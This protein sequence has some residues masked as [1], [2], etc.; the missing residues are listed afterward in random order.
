[1]RYSS[2]PGSEQPQ[3]R[4]SRTVRRPLDVMRVFVCTVLD[5]GTVEVN[6]IDAD[7]DQRQ[8]YRG[9][10]VIRLVQRPEPDD[11]ALCRQTS[12]R[13]LR[14]HV[15]CFIHGRDPEG[16][17]VGVLVPIAGRSRLAGATGSSARR[18]TG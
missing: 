9:T 10:E 5:G 13:L 7:S 16:H 15:R 11:Q 12:L 6:V 1:M 17:L 3:R 14:R 18:S 4:R 2:V 8:R